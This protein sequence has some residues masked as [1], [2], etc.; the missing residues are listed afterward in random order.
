MR[1]R[2]L[3]LPERHLAIEGDAI[4]GAFFDFGLY[5]FHNAVELLERG[6][7]PWFYLPMDK[8]DPIYF[9]GMLVLTRN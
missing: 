9:L 7:G 4:A 8:G 1:P 5:V 6:A 3:H 2:G